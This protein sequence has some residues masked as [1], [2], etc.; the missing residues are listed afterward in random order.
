MTR[1]PPRLCS[2]GKIVAHGVRCECQMTADRERNRRHD[3]RRE[4]ASQRGYD[5]AWESAAREFLSQPANSHCEC[6][7][8]ATLVRHVASIRRYPEMRMVRANWRPGCRRCNARD[9]IRERAR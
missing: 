9:Y 6:G 4:S 7:A 1:R 8:P 5:R 2:C 3:R